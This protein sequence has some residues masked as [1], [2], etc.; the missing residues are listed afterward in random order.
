MLN[1]NSLSKTLPKAIPKTSK[2]VTL[3]KPEN[4][5]GRAAWSRRHGRAKTHGSSC[6]TMHGRASKHSQ[7]TAVLPS[8]LLV[9]SFYLWCTAVQ[10]CCTAVL[11]TVFPLLYFPWCSG[12]PLASN[13]SLNRS[14][15][16]PFYR[17]LRISPESKTKHILGTTWIEGR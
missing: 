8:L 2:E 5:R 3:N 14:W 12:L 9:C 4:T 7:R 1:P 17:I 13:L 11:T 6:A 10:P 16:L 15:S